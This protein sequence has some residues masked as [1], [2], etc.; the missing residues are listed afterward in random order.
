MYRLSLFFKILIIGLVITLFTNSIGYAKEPSIPSASSNCGEWKIETVN[1]SNDNRIGV[2]LLQQATGNDCAGTFTLENRTGTSLGGGYSL[3]LITFSNNANAQFL[4]YGDPFLVPGLNIEIKTTPIDINK[5]AST[6][7][8]GEVTLGS[9]FSVDFSLFLMKTALDLIPLPTGCLISY[10]QLFLI[11]LRT[12]PILETTAALASKGDFIG[13]KAELSR[14]ITVFHEKAADAARDIGIGC[15]A[16]FLKSIL[17]KPVV[18]GKIVLSYITW[19]P[20]VIFDYFKYQGRPVTVILTYVPSTPFTET[21]IIPASNNLSDLVGTWEGMV[22]YANYSFHV[23]QTFYQDPK[24]NHFEITDICPETQ[25]CLNV[26]DQND[27]ESYQL[28]SERLSPELD[29]TYSELD[30]SLANPICFNNTS[31]NF[32]TL[33]C[34]S[35]IDQNTVKYVANGMVNWVAEGILTRQK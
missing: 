1:S 29:P 6:T 16:D 9:Y 4:P 19:V 5:Q 14:V 27:T 3:E 30:L 35:L 33:S 32:Y 25:L 8:Q 20:V 28:T 15:F 10:D 7:F 23:N 13:S 26:L 11:S 21:P 34:F 12:A 31:Q 2:T 17:G 22:T 24:M 18:I